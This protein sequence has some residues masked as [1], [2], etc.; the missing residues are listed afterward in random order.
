MD[1]PLISVRHVT[2][3][4]RVASAGPP[5]LFN[6]LRRAL[7]LGGQ[8]RILPALSD[9]SFSLQHGQSLGLVGNNGA[10]K[11]TM[12]RILSGI[13]RPTSGTCEVR[14]RLT[15]VL[16]LGVGMRENV[17]L[18]GAMIGF[19]RTLLRERFDEILAFAELQD[20]VEARVKELSTGMRQR[21]MF[22]I[23]AQLDSDLL[24]LDE[25]L[26]V[27]DRTFKEKSWE[28]FRRR[29]EARKSLILASHD[30]EAVGELCDVCLLLDHGR[31]RAFGP[32]AEVL[33]LY[34]SGSPEHEAGVSDVVA[35]GR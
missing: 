11:S 25:V 35:A 34:T 17:F 9:V 13:Y 7:W 24:L 20:F 28:V 12:L 26:A 3:E 5:S 15:P 1:A 23:T 31:Q 6:Q 33:N 4:F 22:A 16:E 21:L 14:G 32:T 27:G 18:Y 8:T 29:R 10:G 2:K 30:L 19:T